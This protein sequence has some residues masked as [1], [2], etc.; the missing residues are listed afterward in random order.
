MSTPATTATVTDATTREAS[1]QRRLVYTSFRDLVPEARARQAVELWET[2]FKDASAF[3]PVRF[4]QATQAALGLSPELKKALVQRFSDNMRLPN[5]AL[6]PDPTRG[7]VA[8]E[9][10][11][12]EATA[13]EATVGEATV[14]EATAPGA[15]FK[16]ASPPTN[17]SVTASGDTLDHTQARNT[18]LEFVLSRLL[19]QLTPEALLAEL[20]KSALSHDSRRMLAHWCA[21]PEAP[22]LA[23][24]PA[25]PDKDVSKLLDHLY[26]GLCDALGPTK[27]DRVFAHVF[28][29]AET[30]PEALQFSP[31]SL[32]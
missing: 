16:P 17:A 2:L 23:L 27:T 5:E 19:I 22:Q 14:G 29:Q 6:S 26:N 7:G 24:P 21:V 8:G 9:A 20:P 15:A 30:L 12:G 25:L 3:T 31:K 11:A 32:L 13:G 4:L 1:Y 18:I 28:A 10:T